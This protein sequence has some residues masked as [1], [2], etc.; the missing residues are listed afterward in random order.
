[1]S[2]DVICSRC[3]KPYPDWPNP[4]PCGSGLPN[5]ARHGDYTGD[6]CPACA[7]LGKGT[8][9]I[10]EEKLGKVPVEMGHFKLAPVRQFP[11]IDAGLGGACLCVCGAQLNAHPDG[12][13]PI[14][15]LPTV[16]GAPVDSPTREELERASLDA[17]RD[18]AGAWMKYLAAVGKRRMAHERLISHLR[19]PGSR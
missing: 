8:R 15:L 13:C 1:M 17:E 2:L 12:R 4:C 11:E 18:E 6:R 7:A 9:F 3:D 5:C 19:A 16:L 14:K 10:H